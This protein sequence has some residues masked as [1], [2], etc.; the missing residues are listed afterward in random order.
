MKRLRDKSGRFIC[1]RCRPIKLC[2]Y[3]KK[4]ERR[5]GR[6]YCSSKCFGLSIRGKKSHIKGMTL[7]QRYGIEKAKIIRKRL[8][9]SHKG[10]ASWM[11]GK[12]HTKESIRKI[13]LANINNKK[14]LGK[15]FPH[16]EI[17][18][19]QISKTC[20][21]NG[22]G[23]WMI[24]KKQSE[25]T[26]RKKSEALKGENSPNWKGGISPENQRLRYGID[27]KLWIKKVFTKNNYT[28][29]KCGDNKGG[30]LQSHHVQNFAEY[31][32]LRF[33]IDNG[34][35]FCKKCHK[36]FHDKYGYK[37]NTKEQLKEFLNN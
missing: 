26:K 5:T 19:Q 11:K 34:I 10:Q 33:A 29:Q 18:K 30:N 16:T 22:I 2:L 12:K 7:E 14:R 27:G 21:S 20:E 37:N 1:G 32:E 28:C 13:S 3:C 31:P 6:K 8:S 9:D 35:T 24:G 36:E 15:K 23:K 4:E 25:E 17:T